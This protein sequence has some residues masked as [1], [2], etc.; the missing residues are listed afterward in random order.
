MILFSLEQIHSFI[1][2]LHLCVMIPLMLETVE[3]VSFI[4]CYLVFWFFFCRFSRCCWGKLLYGCDVVSVKKV[5]LLLVRLG[6]MVGWW[7]TV[8]VVG[9]IWV[10]GMFRFCDCIQSVC[11]LWVYVSMG[12]LCWNWLCC[13]WKLIL[14]PCYEIVCR[15][16]WL[17]NLWLLVCFFLYVFF[18][19]PFRL[20]LQVFL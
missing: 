14:V 16:V 4:F 20:E 13:D 18:W 10:V 11:V 19:P 3:V 12:L 8:V 6:L 5:L 9:P 7:S 2:S 17:G 15:F 1:P